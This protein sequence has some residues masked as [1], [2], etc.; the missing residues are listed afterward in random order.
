MGIPEGLRIS[1]G[2]AINI[3][4]EKG[5]ID[6]T[7]ETNHLREGEVFLIYINGE[8]KLKVSS[9]NV[10]EHGFSGKEEKTKQFELD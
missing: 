6:V 1:L 3:V 7:Y 5:Y 10:D 8:E 9:S 2:G 4:T